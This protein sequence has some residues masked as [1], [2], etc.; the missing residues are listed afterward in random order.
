MVL[1]NYKKKT[2]DM[3]QAL[4]AVE[5]RIG[6]GATYTV[7]FYKFRCPNDN[8]LTTEI[9]DSSGLDLNLEVQYFRHA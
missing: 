4:L 1:E 6:N 3:N 9:C 8:T 5:A 7:N 2:I